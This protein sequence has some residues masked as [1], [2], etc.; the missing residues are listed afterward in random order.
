MTIK[1]VFIY[2][3]VLTAWARTAVGQSI[4]VTK[5]ANGDTWNQGQTYAITWT[6]SGSMPATVK[7]SLKEPN[8]PTIVAEIVDGVPNNG[9]YSWAVPASVAPGSYR[10]RVKVK[11]STVLDDSGTFTIMAAVAPTITVTAPAAGAK[12]ARTKTYSVAWTKTGTLPG[13]V[14]IDLYDKNSTAV[15][16]PIAGSAPNS[17]LYSWTIPGDAALGEYRVMVK[18]NG[19]D[20]RDASDVFQVVLPGMM[21]G[22]PGEKAAVQKSRVCRSVQGICIR[23]RTSK[24]S[25]SRPN[26]RTGRGSLTWGI[27]S[28]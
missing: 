21:P 11:N 2:L 26:A 1:R 14:K 20:V 25:R 5:P 27:R 22:I 19:A 18:A 6:K 8:T 12:W 7:I 23:Y 13:T 3:F 9:A 15:V 16:L 4:T 24:S 17:G 28:F 10:V